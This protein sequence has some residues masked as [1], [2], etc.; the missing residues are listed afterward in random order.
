MDT[1]LDIMK[2]KVAVAQ[3]PILFHKS[4]SDWKKYIFEFSASAANSQILVFPEYGCLDMTSLLS[5][6]ER[7]LKNQIYFL[8]KYLKDFLETFAELAKKN[9]QVILA[10]S[11]PLLENNKAYN[12]AFLFNAKG[13]MGFQDK[14]KMTRFENED[15]KV[16]AS[17][18]PQICFETDYCLLGTSICYDV[19]F[20]QFAKSLSHQGAHLLLAPSC[21]ETPH[22]MNRVHIGAQA[23]ALENQ[24]FVAVSQTVG[25]APW[26]PAVDIN[27]GRGLICA[28]PDIGF[29]DDGILIRGELNRPGWIETELDTQKIESVRQQGSVL[30]FQDSF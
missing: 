10:P 14:Y 28:P 21:T 16:S 23:R 20:P 18:N 5:E 2:F 7:Q 15:W 30:N 3:Y 13:V 4:F 27:T 26:S 22:G 17:L 29:P 12:R 6:D 9:S 25:N 8:Q 19:E 1:E 24:F 11:F